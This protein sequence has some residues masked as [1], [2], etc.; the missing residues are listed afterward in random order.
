MD[1]SSRRLGLHGGSL[2]ISSWE[3]RLGLGRP[4]TEVQIF[5]HRKSLT[6]HEVSDL[7]YRSRFLELSLPVRQRSPAII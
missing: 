1:P 6:M 4:I 7:I 2:A 3:Q 5:M